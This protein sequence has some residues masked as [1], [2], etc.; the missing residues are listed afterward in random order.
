[1]N[2]SGNGSSLQH[3]L[4]VDDQPANLNS[5]EQILG[6]TYQV[7]K[8]E[9]GQVCLDLTK[10]LTPDLIL[11]D[12][13]MPVLD[14]L[15]VCR[16]LKSDPTT[17]MIPIIF[18]SALSRLEERLAGYRAGADDYV[19]KPYNVDELLAKIRIALN[20]SYDLEA[21]KAR[22]SLNLGSVA[23][24]LSTCNELDAM[25]QFINGAFDC[26]DLRTLGDRLLETFDHFG[27]RVIVRMLGNGHYFS[28]AG[29]VG[30]L[31][32]EMMEAMYDKGRLIDFGHR[33]LINADHVSV[34]VRN[35]PVHDADRYRRWKESLTLLVGV[36]NNCVAAVENE[37][38]HLHQAGLNSLVKG[39]NQLIEH[40]QDPE[41]Q[42]DQAHAT[43][44]LTHLISVWESS[45]QAS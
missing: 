17:S 44:H 5:L 32:Q 15:S 25:R 10:Q 36:V 43:S 42:M 11:L 37:S 31:D 33:T 7:S 13:D 34:L 4:V 12:V 26:Q 39:L 6:T 27:L 35:M 19:A 30:A 22:A 45:T 14:G 20:S 1:M 28:H 9:N 38:M 2:Q 16:K 29:E 18:V 8:G 3:I 24:S 21:A 40:L 41:L 23:D